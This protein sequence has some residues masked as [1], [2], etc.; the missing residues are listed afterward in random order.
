MDENGILGVTNY[1]WVICGMVLA[2]DFVKPQMVSKWQ[3]TIKRGLR[4]VF[5][6]S[7]SI[8]KTGARRNI[9]L[10]LNSSSSCDDVLL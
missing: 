2:H 9:S 7:S 6:S 5:V 1:K 4:E 8:C 10:S 3:I